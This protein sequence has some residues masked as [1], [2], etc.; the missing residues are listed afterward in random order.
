MLIISLVWLPY[1]FFRKSFKSPHPFCK[2]TYCLQTQWYYYMHLRSSS[3]LPNQ[4]CVRGEPPKQKRRPWHQR[5]VISGWTEILASLDSFF[6]DRHTYHHDHSHLAIAHQS[7]HK[8]R[9]YHLVCQATTC[10]SDFQ[11]HSRKLLHIEF[12]I[13]M[14]LWLLH[15]F[16]FSLSERSWR[17]TL[18]YMKIIA[19]SQTEDRTEL[20]T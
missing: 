6:L 17:C 20:K 4:V 9:R 10:Q 18:W 15:W 14:D 16:G 3:Q 7:I 5:A 1:L 2:F 8:Y 13:T 12:L 11:F 19:E